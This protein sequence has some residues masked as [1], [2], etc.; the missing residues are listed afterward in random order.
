MKVI[1]DVGVEVMCADAQ[2]GTRL[3]IMADC[4]NQIFISIQSKS[5]EQIWSTL[6]ILSKVVTLGFW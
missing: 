5:E 6:L 4:R 1:S 3:W 2:N